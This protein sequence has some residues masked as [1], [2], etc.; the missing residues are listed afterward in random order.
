LALKPL[1]DA[2]YSVVEKLEWDCTFDQSKAIP[3]I[4]RSLSVGKTVHSIDLTGATDYFPL[5]IQLE[6]LI[7]IFGDL[8]DIKLLQ[9]IAQLR[10]KSEM[11]DIQWK[12]G[13]PLGLYPSFGMFTLTH[14]LLLSFLL[15]RPYNNEFLCCW[16]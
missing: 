15:G 1:G 11:G 2:I 12:R 6:T 3:W 8:L 13:Q 5:G 16:R 14:G 7:G 9:S 10:W 4:Q